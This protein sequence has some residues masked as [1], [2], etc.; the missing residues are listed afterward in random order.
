MSLIMHISATYAD[1]ESP[2]LCGSTK[3]SKLYLS[4]DNSLGYI[5][6][7]LG[8]PNLCE[9]CASKFRDTLDVL[10]LLSQVDL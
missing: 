4:K 2:A 6:V 3:D 9:E 5:Q 10:Q 7:V 1:F 8:Y